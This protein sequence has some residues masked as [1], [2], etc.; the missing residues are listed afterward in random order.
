MMTTASGSHPPLTSE[1]RHRRRDGRGLV[2][3]YQ[4]VR[5][6]RA[7]AVCSYRMGHFAERLRG[8]VT[9]VDRRPPLAAVRD[10]KA[11][12]AVRPFVDDAAHVVLAAVHQQGAMRIADF[13]DLVFAGDP[14]EYPLVLNGSMSEAA[15]AARMARYRE[16]LASFDAFT[17][18]T[19]QLR[20]ELAAV[21]PHAR[22]EWVPNGLSTAWVRQGRALHRPWRPGDP[23]VIR[24]LSGS[25]S[26]DRDFASVVPVLAELLRARPDVSLE[27]V[28]PVAVALDG[29]DV[30]RVR[31][32]PRVPYVDLPRL[33]ASSW[34]T[35]A[36]LAPTRFNACKSAIKFLE[37]AAFEAPC[38]ATPTADM[39]RHRDGGALL[40]RN[41]GE[42]YRA[43]TSL[44]DDQ[45]RVAA[46]RRARAWVD[47]HGR[48]DD[49]AA[50]LSRL[51][52]AWKPSH[53]TTR[54]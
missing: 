51:I 48:A 19:E 21:V 52:E 30:D 42:W 12:I 20:D 8:A 25:P 29:L 18:S 38:V 33:L 47:R 1:A 34:V 43:I 2:F 16:G 17:A 11:V 36:P 50:V 44:L 7:S 32:V 41:E 26:H 4:A 3:W 35:L 22:I 46:G 54:H 37:S 27:I 28:G 13:D 40:A 53:K 9:M 6:A 14:A 49:G 5:L 23:R 15:C 45:Q 39:E 31:C 10:A 24:Y